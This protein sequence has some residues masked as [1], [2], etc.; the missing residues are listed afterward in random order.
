MINCNCKIK[1][2]FKLEKKLFMNFIHAIEHDGVAAFLIQKTIGDVTNKLLDLDLHGVDGAQRQIKVDVT[3][4]MVEGKSEEELS[5][6]IVNLFLKRD[7]FLGENLP[8]PLYDRL[9]KIK[10]EYEQGQLNNMFNH[11]PNSSKN[12]PK[13]L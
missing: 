12:K 1:I 13:T 11:T 3:D 9:R 7:F 5:M 8:Q 10:S 6:V 2:I 4:D